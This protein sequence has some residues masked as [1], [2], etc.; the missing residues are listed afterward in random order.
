MPDPISTA[1][2]DIRSMRVRGAALIGKHAATALAQFSGIWRGDAASLDAAAAKLIAARPTAVSLP[3]AVRFVVARAKAAQPESARPAALRAAADEFL[4]RAEDA[5]SQIASQGAALI[6]EGGTVLTICNSQGAI[7]PMIEARK[8]GRAFEAIALETR[9]W[10][11][12]LLTATQLHKGGV[13]VSLAV[14]SAMWFLL[15]E[16]DVVL[17]GADAIAVNGDVVNKIGTAALATLAREKGVPFHCCAESF[18]VALGAPT[19][20]DVHIEERAST[21]I[22]KPGE[23]PVGVR[24]RNPVFDVTDAA[25]VTSYVTELGVLRSASELAAA[26]RRAWG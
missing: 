14:D 10:R 15:D 24:V 2:D 17:V 16:A 22:V 3:N 26:A 4:H 21:E 9:P 11:Q 6:P 18:K 5:L 20:R 1:A 12:G 23:L 8:L 7:R 19:G 25:N 13:S